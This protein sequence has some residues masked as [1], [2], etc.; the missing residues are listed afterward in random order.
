MLQLLAHSL[1][2][3][4]LTGFIAIWMKDNEILSLSSSL[5]VEALQGR[6]KSYLEKRRANRLLEQIEDEILESL[7]TFLDAEFREI[8]S[9][10]K[11][12][13]VEKALELICTLEFYD[14]CFEEA[15]DSK[16]LLTEFDEF[17]EKSQKTLLISDIHAVRSIFG[18]A[19]SKYLS[20]IRELPTFSDDALRALLID[21]DEIL[22]RIRN[23][24]IEIKSA[25]A[26][27][28]AQIEEDE[29]NYRRLISRKLKKIS[30]FGLDSKGLPKK[31]SL[32][33][34]Y[35]NLML[36]SEDHADGSSQK[37]VL[38]NAFS[39]H[40][41]LIV[42]RGEPGSGKTTLLS[43]LALNCAEMSLPIELN[44]IERKI[45]VFIQ[46]REYANRDLPK[47]TDLLE[48]QFGV[49]SGSF[50]EKWLKQI[51]KNGEI[52][53]FLDGFDEV[54]EDRRQEVI[55][56][57]NQLLEMFPN[58]TAV[59]STRPYT[60][61][62]L[63]ELLV[64]RCT[65]GS[66]ILVQ[67]MSSEQVTGFIYNWYLSF[68]EEA[69]S[70]DQKS[71]FEISRDRLLER[72]NHNSTLRSL[73]RNP[74]ICSLI[75]FVNADRDGFVPDQRGDLY[76]LATETLLDRRERERGIEGPIGVSL[77]LG[78]KFKIL[79]CISEYFYKRHRTQLEQ[80]DVISCLAEYL[81]SLALKA[82]Q[83]A[84]ILTYTPAPEL[85]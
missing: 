83:A 27:D 76:R 28:R 56:W 29:K 81:P 48:E 3:K 5:A 16:R 18:F 74:L 53:F 25:R 47:G 43:W 66:Q 77:S 65:L 59:L 35:V 79:G 84:N 54:N 19:V 22:E 38:K 10:D 41:R 82:D 34:A 46:I 67:P 75:C 4:L 13:I 30:I 61:E 78:Q 24:E 52:V 55:T 40:S 6:T 9:G 51:V 44:S 73:I 15:F 68:S 26:N 49:A 8:K 20:I 12:L 57:I 14:A 32:S 21:T 36:T 85:T 37:N 70:V 17:I 2:G 60:G 71:R 69:E 33:I 58:S 7:A 31:Y 64:E 50:S 39:T 62:E 23:I 45:P 11:V 72:L 80:E 42:I 63:E 1:S